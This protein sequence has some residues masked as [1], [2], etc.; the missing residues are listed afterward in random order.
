[1]SSDDGSSDGAGDENAGGRGS[2]VD[3]HRKTNNLGGNR[4]G[5]DDY[6]GDKRGSGGDR[7]RRTDSQEGGYKKHIEYKMPR[8]T[9][10]I[11][12]FKMF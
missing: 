8:L 12:S 6:Q 7:R 9:E 1:M 11:I 2:F 10:P 3:K 4:R 5:D